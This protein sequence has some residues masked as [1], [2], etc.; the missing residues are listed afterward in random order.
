MNE[1]SFPSEPMGVGKIINYTFRTYFSKFGSFALF[2]L[3]IGGAYYLIFLILEQ[4]FAVQATENI[5]ELRDLFSGLSNGFSSISDLQEYLESFS[6]DMTDIS[7]MSRAPAWIGILAFSASL[8]VFPIIYGGISYISTGYFLGESHT[9]AGW[10]SKTLSRYKQLF[11]AN[12]CS[13]LFLVGTGILIA[14][15]LLFLLIILSIITLLVPFL[16]ILLIILTWIAAFI[17]SLFLFGVFSM[18]FPVVIR[19]G[20]SG[21]SA[22]IRAFRLGFSRF[23]RTVGSVISI[24]LISSIISIVFTAVLG[25]LT[26]FSSPG[27]LLVTAIIG[28]AVT[29]FLD[30]IVPIALNMNYLSIRIGNGELITGENFGNGNQQGPELL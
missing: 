8:F 17:F 18:R 29:Q 28:R 16:G 4:I 27:K 15:P 5:P 30:P 24:S 22:I 7:S 25:W 21:F 19:E 14:I 2:S 10:L 6:L 9:P 26:G 1:R 3:L 11:I 20:L 23:W 12:F 13:I